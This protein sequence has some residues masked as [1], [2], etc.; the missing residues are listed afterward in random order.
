MLLSDCWTFFSLESISFAPA[1]KS[2]AT[3]VISVVHWKNIEANVILKCR[4]KFPPMIINIWL[5]MIGFI[6][7]GT[8]QK[9][10]HWFIEISHCSFNLRTFEIKFH[11]R[12]TTTWKWTR[13][14]LN[15]LWTKAR[16]RI[17]HSV[18]KL[19]HNSYLYPILYNSKIACPQTLSIFL[20]SEKWATQSKSRTSSFSSH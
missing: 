16:I 12:N 8:R 10:D 11:R 14:L 3:M 6:L 9:K 20:R 15:V 19:F 18:T 1:S 5:N 13:I 17:K 7:K 4:W 2:S